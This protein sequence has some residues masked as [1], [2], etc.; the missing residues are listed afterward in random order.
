M[1]K[2]E[3][4]ATGIVIIGQVL[5]ATIGFL[6]LMAVFEFPDILRK[7]AEYRLNVFLEN[8]DIIIPIWRTDQTGR[9]GLVHL[10]DFFS[11]FSFPH[12]P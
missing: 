10:A 11:H 3:L 8:K 7:S 6:I 2:S 12:G 5:T 9:I 4:N 1:K